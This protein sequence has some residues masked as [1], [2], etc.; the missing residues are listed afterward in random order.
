METT[1]KENGTKVKTAHWELSAD[2]KALTIKPTSIQSGEPARPL[3]A[4]YMRTSGSAGFAGGWKDM[5]RLE[6]EPQLMRLTPIDH[7]LHLVYPEAGQYADPGLNGTD[8]TVHGQQVP[9]GLTIAIEPNGS[10]EFLITRKLGGQIVNQGFFRLS[11]DRRTL[12]EEY[13]RPE[14]PNERAVLIYEKQ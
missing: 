12:V 13:W 2:Q 1:A 6:S 9:L 3:V 11:E 10:Y 8:A 5:N 14:R 7:S 4:V